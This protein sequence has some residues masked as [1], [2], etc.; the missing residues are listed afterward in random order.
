[1]TQTAYKP[2]K[3]SR[4]Q[5]V[6]LRGLRHHIRI[7]GEE[8]APTLF[9]LH[10]G[11]DASATFQ[12]VVDALKENWRILALDWRGHGQSAWP[13]GGYWYYDYVADLEAFLDM[14]SPDEPA[15]IVG[16]SLGANISH[17][18]AGVR[19]HRVRRMVS[20]DG[21]GLAD[22]DPDTAPVRIGRW[23]DGQKPAR[24]PHGYA[25]TVDMAARLREANPRLSE[26]KSLF[27]AAEV[28]MKN[29]DGTLGW[30]F[31]PRHRTPFPTV[32][33]FAEWAACFKRI[34]APVLWLSAE[35][36]RSRSIDIAEVERRCALIPHS[37]RIHIE[38]VG[39]NLHHEAPAIVAA[40][41]EP[42]LL[43]GDLPLGETVRPAAVSAAAG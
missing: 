10:G 28:S 31:D 13:P 42:F 19:P 38:G 11:R 12:F 1:M 15:T 18:F 14:Q 5:F 34:E 7:W 23:L 3:P 25:N 8:G 2:V 37:A 24:A 39:H 17:I 21:F 22:G 16:H 36:G 43:S 30:A 26:D 27:L 40:K 32:Y 41:I 9:F 4:S 20:L 29:G 35:L 33:R 6:E